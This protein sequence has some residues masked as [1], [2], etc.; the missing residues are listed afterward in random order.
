MVGGKG[1][2]NVG[3]ATVENFAVLDIDA[4]AVGFGIGHFLKRFFAYDFAANQLVGPFVQVYYAG[5]YVAVAGCIAGWNAVVAV[6]PVIAAGV[7]FLEFY[8][9]IAHV[10]GSKNIFLHVVGE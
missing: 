8:V 7:G 10:A 9:G 5:I 1:I 4:V 6:F 2:K 3:C